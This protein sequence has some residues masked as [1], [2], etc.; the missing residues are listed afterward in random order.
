MWRDS[1]FCILINLS[2]INDTKKAEIHILRL[3]IVYK[4]FDGSDIMHYY[5][6]ILSPGADKDRSFLKSLFMTMISL[7][8]HYL[9]IVFPFSRIVS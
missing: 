2:E 6:K 8:D 9:Y 4:H 1:F 7:T 3:G 5:W